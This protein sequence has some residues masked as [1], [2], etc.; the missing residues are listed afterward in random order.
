MTSTTYI[1]DC[2]YDKTVLLLLQRKTEALG[3]IYAPS[4]LLVQTW[5]IIAGGEVK[6][7][8]SIFAG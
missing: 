4:Q 3:G 2:A 1:T 6:L 5:E 8:N 7:V